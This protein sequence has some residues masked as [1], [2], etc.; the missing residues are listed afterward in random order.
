MPKHLWDQAR[1]LARSHKRAGDHPAAQSR[2]RNSRLAEAARAFEAF[3]NGAHGHIAYRLLREQQAHI[4]LFG[5]WNSH[6]SM[7]GQ[8]V[9]LR[10][11]ERRLEVTLV[12]NALKPLRKLTPHAGV[13]CTWLGLSGNRGQSPACRNIPPELFMTFL[14]GELDKFALR[15]LRGLR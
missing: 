10:P 4:V 8:E 7:C 6:V 9:H 5:S 14:E 2:I 1:H 15:I 3:L 13:R 11:G 12:D